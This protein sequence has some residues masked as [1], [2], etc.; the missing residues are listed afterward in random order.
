MTVLKSRK[1]IPT[2]AFWSRE[3]GWELTSRV[4]DPKKKKGLIIFPPGNL[5]AAHYHHHS[6]HLKARGLNTTLSSGNA[7][8]HGGAPRGKFLSTCTHAPAR[9]LREGLGPSAAALAEAG[10]GGSETVP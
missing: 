4:T 7:E 10:G 3:P 6:G 1:A 2:V 5:G 8:G 9:L